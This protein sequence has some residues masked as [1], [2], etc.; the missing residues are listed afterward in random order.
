VT[1][2]LAHQLPLVA[3]EACGRQYKGRVSQQ[4]PRR[5]CTATW[6]VSFAP[7]DAN[8]QRVLTAARVAASNGRMLKNCNS[9][10]DVAVYC[11]DAVIAVALHFKPLLGPGMAVVYS[12]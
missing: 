6:H 5:V 4:H 8:G 1:A 7:K 12:G 2:T 3:S 11:T 10:A 9:C